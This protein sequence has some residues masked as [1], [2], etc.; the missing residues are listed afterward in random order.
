[1]VGSDLI[2]IIIMMV[3]LYLM[4]SMICSVLTEMVSGIFAWRA[5]TTYKG[6]TDF[7][8][9]PK[10]RNLINMV[11]QHPLVAG[12]KRPGWW[13]AVARLGSKGAGRPNEIPL[14]NFLHALKDTVESHPPLDP[15]T[16]EV[17]DAVLNEKN[18]EKVRQWWEGAEFTMHNRYRGSIT[19]LIVLMA[20]VVTAVSNFDSIMVFNTLRSDKTVQ[21][22]VT[23]IMAEVGKKVDLNAPDGMQKA[24]QVLAERAHDVELFGW[25]PNPK[26]PLDPRAFPTDYVGWA[27]KIIGLLITTIVVARTAPFAFDLFNY[28]LKSL[29]KRA[30]V[31]QL[32]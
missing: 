7:F 11:Y 31:P 30:G 32:D 8:L 23:A 15:K 14:V 6:L 17:V 19:W 20:V 1:M 21:A 18:E 22:G 10:G 16:R 5:G 24:L 9:D 3:F 13:D 4:L 29:G 28:L 26:N 2:S 27:M 12:L 25:K